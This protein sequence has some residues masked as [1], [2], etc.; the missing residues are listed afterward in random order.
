MKAKDALIC[1]GKILRTTLQFALLHPNGSKTAAF[2]LFLFFVCPFGFRFLTYSAATVYGSA[3]IIKIIANSG[4]YDL[5]ESALHHSNMHESPLPKFESDDGVPVGQMH[6]KPKISAQMSKRRNFKMRIEDLETLDNAE[7]KRVSSL[8]TD[9]NRIDGGDGLPTERG[10]TARRGASLCEGESVAGKHAKTLNEG[11]SICDF[12]NETR[13]SKES[14]QGQSE[15]NDSSE[16]AEDEDEEDAPGDRRQAV[17]WTEE[18]Q[19]SLMDLGLSELERNNRL[20]NLIAKRMV[21]KSASMKNQNNL[22]DPAPSGSLPERNPFDLPYDSNEEK[23]N[24]TVDSIS[25]EIL[26]P[27][28]KDILNRHVSSFQ[29]P[30]TAGTDEDSGAGSS[31]QLS[32]LEKRNVEEPP[33]SQ[34]RKESEKDRHNEQLLSRDLKPGRDG[35]KNDETADSVRDDL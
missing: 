35:S 21:K 15:A 25:P 12:A 14:C 4:P 27:H 24:L 3:I 17:E 9:D 30:V 33:P 7:G 22:L 2:F 34:F 5:H 19:K 18:D 10:L 11:E 32:V 8:G 29:G 20:E 31:S 16:D 1:T 26:A 13:Q 28:P 6:K 23:P